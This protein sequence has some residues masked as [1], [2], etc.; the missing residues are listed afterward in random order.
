[1]GPHAAHFP[2]AEAF[3]GAE[4]RVS[5]ASDRMGTRLEG[6]PLAGAGAELI[7]CGVVAGAVQVPRGGSPIVL[8]PDHQTTGGYPVVATV[9]TADLGAVAQRLPGEP[10]RFFA[11]DPAAAVERLASAEAALAA[12]A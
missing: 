9:A 7:T 8:G 10:L 4:W 6:P 2:D 1:P 11:V 5:E 12:I 3:F